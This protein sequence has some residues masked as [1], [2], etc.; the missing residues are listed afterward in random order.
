M[1]STL[2]FYVWKSRVNECCLYVASTALVLW[3]LSAHVCIKWMIKLKLL[4]WE[5][6]KQKY[7]SET[8]ELRYCNYEDKIFKRV[9]SVISVVLRETTLTLSEPSR[10]PHVEYEIVR[11][12]SLSTTGISEITTF[13]KKNTDLQG[14]YTLRRTKAILTCIKDIFE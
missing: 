4:R 11:L 1:C 5:R 14:L 2:Q 9:I 12:V 13:K 7:Y 10:Q 8:L 6:Y 3:S